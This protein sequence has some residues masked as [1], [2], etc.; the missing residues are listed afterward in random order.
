M[1]L[2][3]RGG[4]KRRGPKGGSAYGMPRYSLTAGCQDEAW[5]RMGPEDVWTGWLTSQAVALRM[6]K[7]PRKLVKMF[8][9]FAMARAE[10]RPG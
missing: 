6:P 5:P 3:G 8:C 2:Y 9:R 10:T 7:E 1:P 4:A